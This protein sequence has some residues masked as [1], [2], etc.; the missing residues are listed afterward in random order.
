MDTYLRQDQI[1]VGLL[2]IQRSYSSGDGSPALI[3]A[4]N[5]TDDF[6][7]VLSTEGETNLMNKWYLEPWK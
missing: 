2:V 6:V 5:V 3:I 4:T 1:E 7:R